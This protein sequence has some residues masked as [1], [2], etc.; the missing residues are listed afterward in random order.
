MTLF[1]S[2]TATF[3]WACL[4]LV[5][6]LSHADDVDAAIKT[7]SQDWSRV[8][9]TLP[10]AQQDDAYDALESRGAAL[11]A[12]YPQRAEPRVWQAIILSTHAGEHGGLGALG[13]AKHAR[14]LLQEAEKIQ[15][16]VLHGSIYTT[17]GSLYYQV[18]GWPVGFGDKDKARTLLQKA[19]QIDPD[20]IDPNYFYA[21]FLY[22]TGDKAGAMEH[23]KKA[24]AAAPRPDRELADKGRRAQVQK[25]IDTI[26]A[27]K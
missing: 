23:L 18:P 13:M 3:A 25:L 11:I 6:S 1:R 17:L 9:Y 7:L 8:T 22:K 5:P 2:L 21:D 14:D 10:K 12:Q 16:D 26:G 27:E 20:G 15:P 4:A 19:L 24:L